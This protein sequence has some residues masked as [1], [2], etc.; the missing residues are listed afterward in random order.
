MVHVIF[1]PG[2]HHKDYEHA[3]NQFCFLPN[4]WIYLYK[5]HKCTYF[6]KRETLN[7]SIFIVFNL[8]KIY[9]SP[10]EKPNDERAC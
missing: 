4:H 8:N 10:S 2:M 6:I 5:I 3:D 7:H 9:C 1:K